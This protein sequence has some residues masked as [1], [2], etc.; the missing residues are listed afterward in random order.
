MSIRENGKPIEQVVPPRIMML[1]PHE[2]ELDPRIR[3]VA[4]LCKGFGRTEIIGFVY[5]L[6]KPQREYDSLVST[7]RVMAIDYPRSFFLWF[8]D[9]IQ[10][11][12]HPLRLIYLILRKIWDVF[13]ELLLNFK[14]GQEIINSIKNLKSKLVDYVR[15]YRQ[16][17]IKL[18]NQLHAS[19]S[20]KTSQAT[21]ARRNVKCTQES[22]NREG[23][24]DYLG[25]IRHWFGIV[26]TL[27][28]ISN[29]LFQRART[30]SIIPRVVICHDIFALGAAVKYK[31]LFGTPIIYDSHELWPEADLRSLPWEKKWTA[32]F[33]QK[34]IRQADL[35]ITV[36]PQ[37]ANHLEKLYQIEKVISVPNAEPL[38]QS[39]GTTRAILEY[40]LKF[41][42]QGQAT[43]K[44]G[45]EEFLDIWQ[46][47]E[48]ERA[49]L[50]V[51]CPENPFLAC[52]RQKYQSSIEKRKIIF[53]PAVSEKELVGA[54]SMADVG[55]IPYTGPNLN[56]VY[57]CPNKLSQYMQAGL[58]IFHNS[59]QLFV[60]EMINKF[61]CGLSYDI[62]HPET[63]VNAISSLTSNLDLVRKYQV[64]SYKASLSEFNWEI[65]SKPYIEAI[66][67]FYGE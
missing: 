60:S 30:T 20:P 37:I 13:C 39:L 62:N 5:E 65:Q 50:I 34:L 16:D 1:V 33:E 17:G 12:R 6:A 47:I 66:Q 8:I 42:I 63:I 27:E 10:L 54:A 49:V 23:I 26:Y 19:P 67:R 22:K 55:V 52:L 51:R 25:S 14:R 29:T 53:A 57:A 3:W 59:D 24:R 21:Q 40:P 28:L 7:D 61:D 56:H 2:P 64:N 31:H 4:N 45:I 18:K 15:K 46:L 41:L 58:V 36:N 44:R 9:V 11:V 32:S 43:P 38:P 48:D 35:V